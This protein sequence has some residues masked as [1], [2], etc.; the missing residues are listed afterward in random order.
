MID[1]TKTEMLKSTVTSKSSTSNATKKG[2]E[3]VK[4]NN[5]K[6]QEVDYMLNTIKMIVKAN[7]ANAEYFKNQGGNYHFWTTSE[8]QDFIKYGASQETQKILYNFGKDYQEKVLTEY[9]EFKTTHKS[10]EATE[11]REQLEAAQKKL[12]E[13]ATRFSEIDAYIK[14]QKTAAK[15]AKEETK[16]SE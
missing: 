15:A 5:K 4:A 3:T 12:D 13:Y 10:M 9:F 6:K 16:E 14:A 2:G 11:L 8:W 1:M 7:N